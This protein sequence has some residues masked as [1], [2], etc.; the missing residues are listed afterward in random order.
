M[1]R[2]D[3]ECEEVVDVGAGTC[4]S[5]PVGTHF[6]FRSLGENAL[7]AIAATMPPWPGDGEAVPVD[8]PWTPTVESG[9][10]LG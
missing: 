5:V 8:G 4:V 7:A 10:G 3:D 9:P 6:Q 1:R 2:R